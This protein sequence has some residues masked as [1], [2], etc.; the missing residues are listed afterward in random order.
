VEGLALLSLSKGGT[1]TGMTTTPEPSQDH[2]SPDDPEVEPG[3]VAENP[4]KPDEDGE[5]SGEASNS[6]DL[7]QA[8]PDPSGIPDAHPSNSPDQD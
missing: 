8:P 4:T 5:A 3:D 1:G 6:G 7:H 2:G